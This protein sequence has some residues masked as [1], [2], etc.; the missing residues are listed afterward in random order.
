MS[1]TM[2]MRGVSLAVLYVDASAAG[3]N[4]GSTPTN[5]LTSLPAVASLA[6]TTIYIV[7]RTHTQTWTNGTCATTNTYVIGMP[8]TTDTLYYATPTAAK[9]AW[10]ADGTQYPI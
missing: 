10:D 9:T 7:R 5:A 6:A 1:D 3:T 8:V 2:F 4:D